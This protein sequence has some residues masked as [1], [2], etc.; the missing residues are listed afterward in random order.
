MQNRRD[1]LHLMGGGGALLMAGLPAGRALALAAPPARATAVDIQGDAFHLNGQPTYP[2]RVFRGAK[3][4]G[5]L[6]TSR[7]VNCIADDQNP[8]TRGMWA[9]RD[10]PWDPERNTREFI[11]AL[12]LYRAHGLTSVAFNIQGG[13]PM[14]YGWHQP[15]HLSGYTPDGHL[16]PDYRERLI[17]VLDALD[18]QGMVAILGLFYIAATPALR[19]EA[20]VIRAADEVIDL[21]CEKG[22]THVLI[23]VGNEVD[24]APWAYDIIK[25]ERAHELVSRVQMRSKGKVGNRQGRL[26]VS[27]SLLW[28]SAIPARLLETVDYV[29]FH[30]NALA[31]PDGLRG[32]ATEI[33][34]MPGYRGQPLLI[35]EDDHFDFDKPDND[36]MA[37]L[38]QHVGWGYFDYR[39]VT[40]PFEDGYQSLPVDWG[41]T[42]ARKKAFFR[43]IAE[44]TGT[45]TG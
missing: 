2:G 41:I 20:A 12:P 34:A 4:E 9:Y 24:L 11:A 6:F 13:S 29:L 43:A 21:I 16:R 28:R 32:R 14:G 8:E 39:Q 3:V 18:A 36:L 38:Q 40:E 7:M 31:T 23:E 19:D 27:T 15:W 26:L 25:P 17:R 10:G 5:L 37:A 35:N 22:Y 1:I 30:G 44:I 33:R 42:S 45:K